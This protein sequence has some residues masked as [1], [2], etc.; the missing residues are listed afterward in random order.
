MQIFISGI[1]TEIGKTIIAAILTEALEADYWKPVQSGDLHYSDTQKVQNLISNSKSVFH[2][3][4][5]RLNTPASPHYSA[6]LDGVKI[7]AEEFKTPQ[8]D[9]H[10]I[11]EGAGGLM[12]PLNESYM[13][14]DLIEQLDVPLVLVIRHYLGS[15]NHSLLSIDILKKRKIPILGLVFNGEP[16]PA[17]ESVILSY[18]GLP[19]LF[20]VKEE[21]EFTPE[22]IK[23]YAAKIDLKKGI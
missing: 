1:G 23:E 14:L 21:Q 20:S 22:I 4:T 17:S 3:E 15:I 7:K 6:N 2:S 12:V 16:N 11:I 13:M 5:Y 19:L 8:T 10:L 9:N 18:S